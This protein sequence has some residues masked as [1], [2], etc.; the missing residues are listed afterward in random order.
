M[1]QYI[2]RAYR[3]QVRAELAALGVPVFD[4]PASTY[5]ADGFTHGRYRHEKPT[6]GRHSNAEYGALIVQGLIDEVRSRATRPA[7]QD[8]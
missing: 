2:D 7:A 1:V 4:Q 8:V 5:D 6:D 3:A